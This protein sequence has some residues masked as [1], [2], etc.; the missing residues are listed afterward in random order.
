MANIPLLYWRKAKRAGLLTASPFKSEEEFEQTVFETPDVLGDMYLLKRQIRGGSKP[1]IP[2]II[3]VDPD[4]AVC[5][6]E[7]KNTNV[8]A[9]VIPQVP[10]TDGKFPYSRSLQS[11]RAKRSISHE[12]QKTSRLSP[13]SPS[14]TSPD[15]PRLPH[16]TRWLNHVSFAKVA[17]LQRK[18][19]TSSRMRNFVLVIA[20]TV[21]Y[22]TGKRVNQ[23]PTE[24]VSGRSELL[25]P[26]G[27]SRTNAGI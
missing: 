17:A 8:D 2:D 5:V 25:W 15:F 27:Y 19:I 16:T 7:M 1:G 10:G 12:H 24:E 23:D 6:I 22:F 13:T 14:P 9:G 20:S 18:R 4:G 21:A 26:Y 11:L 3:G